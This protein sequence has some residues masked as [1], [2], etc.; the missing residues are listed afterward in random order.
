[1]LKWNEAT[2]DAISELAKSEKTVIAKLVHESGD[3]SETQ[4]ESITFFIDEDSNEIH[5]YFFDGQSLNGEF[6]VQSYAEIPEAFHSLDSNQKE[7][8]KYVGKK[9]LVK[10]KSAFDVFYTAMILDYSE[11]GEP[12]FH[13]MFEFNIRVENLGW[14]P[15]PE[16][17]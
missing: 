3:E 5:Y 13:E 4:I 12:V 11:I 2:Q 16:S 8:E 6:S 15:L 10:Q 1:M 14:L 9:V 17:E 7:L